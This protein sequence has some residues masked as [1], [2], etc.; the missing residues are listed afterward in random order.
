MLTN[1]AGAEPVGIEDVPVVGEPAGHREPSPSSGTGQLFQRSH[2]SGRF[3]V[4]DARAAERATVLPAHHALL[5]VP[6]P[7]GRAVQRHVQQHRQSPA[8]GQ[9][10][11]VRVWGLP[12]C[13]ITGFVA[14]ADQ[15]RKQSVVFVV[16]VSATIRR[17]T[18]RGWRWRR[19]QFRQRG[20]EDA[21]LT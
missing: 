16:V 6:P 19:R 7:A 17:R 21:R 9:T 14:G 12:A 5:R 1:P 8:Q 11:R 10:T 20:H 4:A 2:F 15:R 3:H 13:R 18:G